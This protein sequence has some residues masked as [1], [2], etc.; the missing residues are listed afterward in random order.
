MQEFSKLNNFILIVGNA[1]SGSTLLGSIIDAHPK[2]IIA[3]ET[4]AS[5]HFWRGLSRH[6]ILTEIFL[7]SETNRSQGRFSEGYN[8]SIQQNETDDLNVSVMGD[9]IWNPAT[10]LL[11]GNYSLLKNLE[12]TIGAPIKIIHAIRNPFDVIATMHFRSKAPIADRI[13]WYF[14]HCDAVC[15]ISENCPDSEFLNV[16]HEELIKSPDKTIKDI[17]SLINTNPDTHHI[18]SCKK[19][20]FAKSKQTRF[21]VNWQK[22]D[23]N[24]IIDKMSQYAFLQDYVSEDYS[25]LI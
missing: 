19:L 1:R 9:K 16:H 10:L 22:K 20:L 14:I 21:N 23:I 15:A 3:N 2:A 11:H 18:E 6:E 25:K 12:K 4:S 17:C 24:N 8:Y 13:L 7:N 5:A